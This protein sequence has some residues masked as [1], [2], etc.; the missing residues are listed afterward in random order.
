MLR[1]SALPYRRLVTLALLCLPGLSACEC[2]C[3]R[4]SAEVPDQSYTFPTAVIGVAVESS[5]QAAAVR[6]GVKRVADEYGLIFQSNWNEPY[7]RLQC[8]KDPQNCPDSFFPPNPRLSDGFLM[9]RHEYSDRCFVVT[10]ADYSGSWTARSLLAFQELS[11]NLTQASD[12]HAQV[13][14]RP[15]KEQNWPLSNTVVDPERP[16]FL[17]ELCVRMG[18]PDPRPQGR[19]GDA[20]N[21]PADASAH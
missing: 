8:E 2:D 17:Q 3:G 10:L 14:V 16:D 15:K 1:Y 12:G 4:P 21:K 13:M 5:A 20:G 18:L 11:A 19:Q 9:R 7:P 6:D